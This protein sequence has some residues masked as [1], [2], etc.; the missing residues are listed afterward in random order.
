MSTSTRRSFPFCWRQ[1]YRTRSRKP[2][3]TSTTRS[4]VPTN[5]HPIHE[6]SWLSPP[7]KLHPPAALISYQVISLPSA[8]TSRRKPKLSQRLS[9]PLRNF[10]L[11][12]LWAIC[13]K[14]APRSA[15][16]RLKVYAGL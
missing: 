6:L 7:G 13:R 1:Q 5:T 16:N 11:F 14:A 15:F 9:Q 8:L 4:M 12:P 10:K 3:I 2:T